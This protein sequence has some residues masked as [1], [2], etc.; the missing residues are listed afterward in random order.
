MTFTSPAP[1]ALARVLRH[2]RI[3]A[4]TLGV[5]LL[6]AWFGSLPARTAFGEILDHSKAS[7]RLVNGFDLGT[8]AELMS[9]PEVAPGAL[10]AAVGAQFF[11][12]FIFLLFI[13]GG[14]YASY[15]A[16]TKPTTG[17]F[18]HACGAAFW[19]ML[20]LTLTSLLPFALVGGCFALISKWST[21]LEA[22][23][24]ERVSDYAL[25]V[26]LLAAGL[27]MTFVRAWFDLAQ[28]KAVLRGERGM[29]KLA[30]RT[31]R[32]VTFRLYVTYVAL[33]ALRLGLTVALLALWM[34]LAPESTGKVFLL[35]Q[36]I[37]LVAITTRLWQRAAAVRALEGMG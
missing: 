26:G 21:G 27:L 4:W 34:R 5:S 9:S 28:A 2:P 24:D 33:V 36:L 3:I 31:F 1:S 12:F 10:N 15:G 11:V 18:F 17:E 32:K 13:S 37:V 35:M 23:P 22:S 19:R 14:I 7:A 20:R 6:L 25:G 8:F 30:L 16:E 29:F